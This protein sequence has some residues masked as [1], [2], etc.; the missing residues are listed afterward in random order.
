[1]EEAVHAGARVCT[2][3]GNGLPNMINRHQNPIWWQLACDE[4]TGIFITDGHH[5]PADFIKVALRAKTVQRFVVVSDAAHL[6]GLPPGVYDF[7]GHPAVLAPD[8]RVGFKG[9]PYLAGSSATMLQ[10][11]NFLAA[12]NLLSEADLWKVGHVNPLRLIGR[13]LGPQ[14]AG[15]PAVVFKDNQ[16]ALA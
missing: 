8:G 13:R 10:C 12:Q 16:F 1:M 15:A 14:P 11:I 2:H 6:A 7:N 9:T 5:L 4:L 3:L